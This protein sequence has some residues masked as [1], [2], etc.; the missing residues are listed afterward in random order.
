MVYKKGFTLIELLVVVTVIAIL[1]AIA[2]PSY[3]QNV[4]RAARSE[5]IGHVLELASTLSKVKA[6]TMSYNAGD[7]QTNHTSR[8]QISAALDEEGGF[9]ITA[10]PIKQQ[11]QDRCGEFVYYAAGLWLFGSGLNYDDCVS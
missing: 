10:T 8:Y 7:G 9:I 4:Q 1:A 3:M 5:A 11:A 6:S 2:I